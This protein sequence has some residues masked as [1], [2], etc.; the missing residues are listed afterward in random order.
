[1]SGNGRFEQPGSRDRQQNL[2][3]AF[4]FLNLLKCS[5]K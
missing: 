1:M 2:I 3:N 4:E 5:Q